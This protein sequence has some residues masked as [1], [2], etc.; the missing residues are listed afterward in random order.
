MEGF[1]GRLPA[2]GLVLALGS[3]APALSQGS[4]DA[5]GTPVV[6]TE[7][8]EISASDLMGKP[9]IDAAGDSL[10][11]VA[12]IIITTTGQVKRLVISRGGVWGIGDEVVA[13]DFKTVRLLPAEGKILAEGLTKDEIERHA[14]GQ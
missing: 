11:Q 14:E 6:P 4:T 13:I 10:G 1:S 3:A 7:E 2:L 12:D 8:A 5:P 9:V